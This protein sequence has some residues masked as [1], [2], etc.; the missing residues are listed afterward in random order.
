VAAGMKPVEYRLTHCKRVFLD[1]KYFDVPETVELAVRCATSLGVGF[2]TIHGNVRNMQAAVKGR[3]NSNL[4]LLAVTV[5]TSYDA[6][7]IREPGCEGSV[8]EL[9]LFRAQKALETGCDGVVAS[10][11]EAKKIRQLAGKKLLIVTPGIRP[12][13]APKQDQ[14]RAVTPREAILAGADY[15]VVGR[16]IAADPSPR[17]AAERIRDEMQAAMQEQIQR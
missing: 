16:P 2:L 5:L 14:K 1:L 4:K 12:S 13:G 10:G 6:S 7:D 15:L 8:E 9:V 17:R 3:G 11:Q